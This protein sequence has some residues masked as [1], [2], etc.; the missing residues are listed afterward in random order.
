[1]KLKKFLI[2]TLALSVF[3]PFNPKEADA[4]SPSCYN[5][6]QPAKTYVNVSAATLWKEPGTKRTIDK[7]SLSNPVDMR[8]WTAK[9]PTASTRIWLTG[10]TET[11]G[12][13]GQEI[14]VLKTSG[15][16]VQVAVKDQYTSKSK[17]G[18]PG[19]MPKSQVIIQKAGYENCQTANIK[20]KTAFLYNDK[21]NKF[22]E[23]SFNTRLPII[24]SEKDWVQVMTPSNQVK[25]IKKSDINI[26]ASLS[27]IP[28]PNSNDLVNT[29][30]M[31]LGLPYLWA[32]TS[33]YGFDCSGFTYSIYKYHGILLPRDASEQIKKGK[34]VS[35]TQIQPGDLLFFAYNKGKG[36]VHHVAM[37]AGNGKMI[38][39]PKAGRTVEIIS[40]NTSPYKD[41]YAGSRRY[42]Q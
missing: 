28:K 38:H 41:E 7:Y 40:I 32:G 36:K 21:S 9:M 12:L 13:Y 30:K 5:P 14:K 27:K 10:K 18:Y 39:S 34:F 4:A 35:K 25:W 20:A 19:W 6:N 15:S 23:V 37:Y 8:T 17:Y 42:L 31:F 1:M 29:G 11:Q 33:A 2:A 16:W 26:Y 24:K 22:L 3:L